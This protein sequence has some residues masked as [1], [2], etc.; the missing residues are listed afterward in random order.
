MIDKGVIIIGGSA[1]ATAAALGTLVYSVY[2]S[3]HNQLTGIKPV[4]AVSQQGKTKASKTT[5]PEKKPG[6]NLEKTNSASKDPA[7]KSKKLASAPDTKPKPAENGATI[8]AKPV[9]PASAGAKPPSFDI[10]RVEPSGDAIVAGRS[11][12]GAQ[13]ELLNNGKTIAKAKSG[14]TGQFVIIPKGLK[15]GAHQLSLRA[16]A[17]DK[18]TLSKQGVAVSVPK[19]GGKDVMV[20]LAEPDKPTKILS[21]VKPV[22]Q[23]PSPTAAGTNPQAAKSPGPQ[24]EQKSAAD[25]DKPQAVPAP[26]SAA[27]VKPS[28]PATAN[29]PSDPAPLK[30][31]KLAAEPATQPES[32]AAKDAVKPSGKA[33]KKPV[34]VLIRSVEAE[35]K[36]GFFVSGFAVPG[37]R[38]RVYLNQSFIAEVQA[39]KDQR[40][41]IRVAKGMSAGSYKVRADLVA[42]GTGKVLSRAQVP[43]VYPKSVAPKVATARSAPVK[44]SSSNANA[45]KAQPDQPAAAVAAQKQPVQAKSPEDNKDVPKQIATLPPKPETKAVPAKPAAQQ[46]TGKQGTKVP[47]PDKPGPVAKSQPAPTEPATPNTGPTAKITTPSTPSERRPPSNTATRVPPPITGPS[48]PVIA[49]STDPKSINKPA[50]VPK[51]AARSAPVKSAPPQTGKPQSLPVAASPSPPKVALGIKPAARPAHV[52]IEKLSTANVTKGDSLWRIS[53]NIWGRGIRYTQIYEANTDQIR[54]PHLIFPGQVLVVPRAKPEQKP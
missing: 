23:S 44:T 20:A 45:A 46:T 35:Q 2:T 42:A 12:P 51:T 16:T 52:V 47:A 36:G 22:L 29:K 18:P 21:D 30:T 1:I 11:E 8:A 3:Q 19:R 4:P 43:F 41:S 32:A 49:N 31:A 53:R 25:Q 33:A 26:A 39:D 34:S 13:I 24:P 50:P 48:N 27:D 37:S 10:V 17:K 6:Q 5:V 40:W 54:N 7:V 15:P 14:P 38:I 9:Q 28:K